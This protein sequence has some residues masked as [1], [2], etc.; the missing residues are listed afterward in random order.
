MILERVTEVTQDGSVSV[1]GGVLPEVI[2]FIR[3]LLSV[4]SAEELPGDGVSDC[5]EVG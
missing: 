4:G 2:L 5:V 1:F 3:L